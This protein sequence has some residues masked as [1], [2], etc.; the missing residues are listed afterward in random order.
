MIVQLGKVNAELTPNSTQS[1]ANYYFFSYASFSRWYKLHDR[2]YE[3]VCL[4]LFCSNP[5]Y[6]FEGK[7]SD[8]IWIFRDIPTTVV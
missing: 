6:T 7:S 4:A 2:K 8:E 1:E 5:H 3:N